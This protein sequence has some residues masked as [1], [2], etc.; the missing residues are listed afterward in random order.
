[1]EQR[2][3][4]I[5]VGRGKIVSRPWNFEAMCLVNDAQVGGGQPGITKMAIGA[6]F[7]LFE[8]TNATEDYLKSL[9]EKVMSGLCLKVWTW[10]VSDIMY[11]NGI[12][13]GKSADG[14][15]DKIKCLRDIYRIM[16][17]NCFKVPDEIGRQ[18]PKNVFYVLA[19]PEETKE[20]LTSEI[21]T[22][23]C[24]ALYGL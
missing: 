5:K 23:G 18:I 11:F 8:G 16:L 12:N 19:Q 7:Y 22:T 6:V 4:V 1:M 10:Y 9:S 24:A 13:T 14:E 21:L 17:K 20:N 2:V 3:L 15:G